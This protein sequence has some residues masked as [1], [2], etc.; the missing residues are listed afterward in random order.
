MNLGIDLDGVLY[1]WHDVVYERESLERNLKLTKEDFWKE[2][3][4]LYPGMAED[5]LVRIRHY[6]GVR[7]IYDKNLELLNELSK[8]NTLFYI[9]A[10]HEELR[11]TTVNW[12]KRNNLPQR[13]NLI[14]SPI[15]VIPV[16]LNDIDIFVED[17]LN[18]AKALSKY[19]RVIIVESDHSKHIEHEFEIISDFF[20]LKDIL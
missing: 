12:M 19:C 18:H 8:T 11:L 15:K 13:D 6:Y 4:T 2:I 20:K 14:F 16:V 10:R 17:N 9:T 1:P 3:H 5:N 7:N